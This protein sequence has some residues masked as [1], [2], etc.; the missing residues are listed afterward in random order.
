MYQH[1]LDLKDTT[2]TGRT[3]HVSSF[4]G[5]DTRNVLDTHDDDGVVKPA[6]VVSY[7]QPLILAAKDR[8]HTYDV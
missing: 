4:P 8:E 7:G 3:F 5:K 2:R 6:T 1:T